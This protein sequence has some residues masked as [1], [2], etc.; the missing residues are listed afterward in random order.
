M[1]QISPSPPAEKF[2]A[3]CRQTKS[4]ADFF[5]NRSTYDGL[6]GYCKLCSKR[7]VDACRKKNPANATATRLRWMD[8]L[9]E[10]VLQKLGGVCRKCGFSDHRALQIDH[11]Y[12]DGFKQRDARGKLL[13]GRAL[14]L[15]EVLL[16]TQGRF[17][18][19]CAN[20]NMIKEYELRKSDPRRSSARSSQ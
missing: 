15:K 12:N 5:K 9:R 17:Q 14:F 19:L 13:V 10:R 16:D 6:G 11:V 8:R 18:L 20:H 2:C 3:R 1:T 7:T 4:V